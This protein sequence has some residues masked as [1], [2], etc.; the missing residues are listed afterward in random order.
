MKPLQ[1][2]T[3]PLRIGPYEVMGRLGSGGMGVVYLA[4]S[5]GPGRLVAI[6]TIRAD[7]AKEHGYH[8]RFA[9]EIEVARTIRSPYIAQLVDFDP[10]PAKPWLA[11][12]LV[13]GP[14]LA[15]VLAHHG[16]LPVETVR[17]LALDL[18]GALTAIHAARIV[19]RDLKP[20]NIILSE[21]GPRLLDFG[22]ARP[23]GQEG[24]TA[25]RQFIGTSA[26]A[27]PEQLLA[28]RADPPSDVFS[29]GV[30]LAEAAGL[31]TPINDPPA[32]AIVDGRTP[33][34]SSLPPDL[35]SVI[36]TCLSQSP[37]DRPAAAELPGML[38]TST[39]AH[40][41]GTRWL[42]DSAL[43]L[44]RR[45]SQELLAVTHPVTALDPRFAG[46]HQQETATARM[47]WGATVVP[48]HATTPLSP[49]AE[50]KISGA[51]AM[52]GAALFLLIGVAGFSLAG[53]RSD[54]GQEATPSA[55]VTVTASGRPDNA[56]PASPRSSKTWQ[57]SPK[58]ARLPSAAPPK[59]PSFTRGPL[60]VSRYRDPEYRAAVTSVAAA[61][62]QLTV[63]VSARGRSDLREAETTCLEVQGAEGTFTV[64]PFAKHA[65]TERPGAFDGTLAFPL[66]V[67]GR[68]TLRYSCQSDY[69]GVDL[70][71][72]SVP[73]ISISRYTDP[74]YFAVV[75]SADRTSRGLQLVFV[76]TGPPDLRDPNTSCLNRGAGEEH[77]KSLELNRSEK[78]LNLFY[79][80]VMNFPA[81]G[82]NSTFSYSCSGD[83]SDA[84]LP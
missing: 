55:T 48:P 68:Y 23:L 60:G 81:V 3:D 69:T 39:R 83:Y 63:T 47:P 29:L 18:A 2:G 43:L 72:A 59:S 12:V 46:G 84:S 5:A 14:N 64:L 79:Y 54:S 62:N 15:E 19:H 8:E 17:V 32:A 73:H 70:G 42:P 30:V 26:Y 61:R 21:D 10:G 74:R 78:T 58:P 1:Y 22:I 82:A 4:R 44:A 76:S 52:I 41:K 34:L 16:P 9:R 50:K 71:T 77:T 51:K 75:L 67:S 40:R 28:H 37:K 45:T 31:V 27:S 24:L 35:R 53:Q 6:K 33:A 20:S 65:R 11:T 36:Q 57:P 66:L 49:L 13:P 25:T 7:L 56:N 38:A 80:G